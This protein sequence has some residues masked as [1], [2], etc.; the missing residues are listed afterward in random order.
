MLL[1]GH[2]HQLVVMVLMDQHLLS[3]QYLVE[4]EVVV[5]LMVV[6][7]LVCHQQEVQVVE[8]KVRVMVHHGLVV[9]RVLTVMMV[10][11]AELQEQGKNILEE[12]AAV[13]ALQVEMVVIL[14]QEQVVQVQLLL[15]QVH[16]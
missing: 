7:R 12:A 10:V 11:M 6:Q 2:M 5:E 3:L 1:V 8:L 15:L 4:A 14:L 9:F 16:L 13:L